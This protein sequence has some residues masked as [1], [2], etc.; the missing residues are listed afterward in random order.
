MNEN[1][2][3]LFLFPLIVNGEYGSYDN[4]EEMLIASKEKI[5]D[6]DFAITLEIRELIEKGYTEEQI[7]NLIQN[8][9]FNEEDNINVKE[10][11][12]LK[13]NAS[14]TLIK[15]KNNL[16]EKENDKNE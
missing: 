9:K 6:L 8:I 7:Y 11:E 2:F 13:K 10:E 1:I 15:I 14:K 5:Q 16:K 4:I 12:Y 3:N